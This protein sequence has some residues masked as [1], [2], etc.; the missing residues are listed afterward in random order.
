MDLVG[1]LCV[2]RHLVGELGR[3]GMRNLVKIVPK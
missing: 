3:T 1:E 2:E